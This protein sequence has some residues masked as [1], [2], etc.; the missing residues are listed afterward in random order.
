MFRFYGTGVNSL[1]TWLSLFWFM[2]GSHWLI[3]H[4][5]RARGSQLDIGRKWG[6]QFSQ[7]VNRPCSSR[8]SVLLIPAH[9]IHR[10]F[11]ALPNRWIG[12]VWKEAGMNS[13]GGSQETQKEGQ[14][15]GCI[16]GRIPIW[17]NVIWRLRLLRHINVLLSSEAVLRL[18][19]CNQQTVAV[20]SCP[21][22]LEG[23]AA[24]V[25]DFRF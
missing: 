7:A 22:Q 24:F 13:I 10:E 8:P 20:F 14:I 23:E 18:N 25:W 17:N 6:S 3:A 9:H 2:S 4:S 19:G 5:V 12:S 15:A 21:W 16:V 11:H 1:W